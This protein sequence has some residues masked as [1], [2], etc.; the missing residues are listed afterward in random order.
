V[1]ASTRRSNS[2]PK[3]LFV[4]HHAPDLL[5]NSR[6]IQNLGCHDTHTYVCVCN[7]D[8]RPIYPSVSTRFSPSRI[9]NGF[10]DPRRLASTSLFSPFLS[11]LLFYPSF[12]T[13]SLLSDPI[14]LSPMILLPGDASKV[15]GTRVS[16]ACRRTYTCR[17]TLGA[18]FWHVHEREETRT[19]GRGAAVPPANYFCLA[20]L[21]T[22]SQLQVQERR[23]ERRTISL[24]NKL[25]I[26]S[27]I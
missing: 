16:I 18:L 22:I 19:H 8:T 15:T 21:K 24:I 17:F 13:E 10:S 14:S 1:N 9:R 25:L 7:R 4:F 5:C 3:P 20:S 12:F 2:K 27:T 11:R 6:F 23:Q 26:N